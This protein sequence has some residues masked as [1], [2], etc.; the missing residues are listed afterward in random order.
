MSWVQGLL[1]YFRVMSSRP[2]IV[3]VDDAP[4]VRTVL[5]T[6]FQ[7]SGQLDVVGEGADGAAA[8]ELAGRHRPALMLLDVSMPGMDGLEALPKVRRA[9]PETRVVMYS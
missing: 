6:F 7:V 2:T 5:R 4:E 9:S 3:V 8:V 1:R